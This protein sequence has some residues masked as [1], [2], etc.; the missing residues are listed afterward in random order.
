MNFSPP[1]VKNMLFKLDQFRK[2]RDAH[3]PKHQFET[4][5]LLYGLTILHSKTWGLMFF[6]TARYCGSYGECTTSSGEEIWISE[7]T[8]SFNI[9]KPIGS[10][11]LVYLPLFAQVNFPNMDPLQKKLQKLTLFEELHHLP[12]LFMGKS[13]NVL[14]QTSW[15]CIKTKYHQIYSEQQR[16]IWS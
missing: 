16:H 13:S 2:F 3:V 4:T 7:S 10:M 12:K 11:G 5:S 1:F 15:S 14:F 6:S 9:S 8:L